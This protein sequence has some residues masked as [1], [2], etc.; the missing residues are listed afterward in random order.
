MYY[1]GQ[2]ILENKSQTTIPALTE[3]FKNVSFPSGRFQYSHRMAAL[4]TK[5]VP[6]FQR[7]ERIS[8]FF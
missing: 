2:F 7:L 4:A 8:V 5:P 3:I 6:R 1:L